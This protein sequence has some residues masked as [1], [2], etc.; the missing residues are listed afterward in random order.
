ME[1]SLG[2]GPSKK[3]WLKLGAERGAEGLVEGPPLPLLLA[4]AS[5]SV[6][7]SSLSCKCGEALM[8]ELSLMSK[9]CC[10]L[11][12]QEN[13]QR[14]KGPWWLRKKKSQGGG[15]GRR[16]WRKKRAGVA[17]WLAPYSVRHLHRWFQHHVFCMYVFL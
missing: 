13:R 12:F 17:S 8:M 16:Q 14:R 15:K 7:S 2:R 1:L 6:S 4:E 5:N 3:D 11:F 9:W 10:L